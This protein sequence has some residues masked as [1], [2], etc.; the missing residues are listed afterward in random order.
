MEFLPFFLILLVATFFSAV[1]Q[2]LHIPWVVALILGGIIIGPFGFDLLE[3]DETIYFLGQIGIVFLMFMAGLETKVS[4][5]RS[6]SGS[7]FTIAT[8]NTVIPF[9]A[10]FILALFF[11]M[12]ISAA[13]LL[14]IIFISSSVGVVLPSLQSNGLLSTRPGRV[15]TSVVVFEDIFSLFLLAIFLHIVIPEAGFSNLPLWAFLPLFFLSLV[16]LRFIIPKIK[17]LVS[18]KE[19][20]PSEIDEPK[21]DEYG[22]GSSND[23][24]VILVA[25]LGTVVVFG[26]LGIH[27]IAGGFFAGLVLSDTITS[28]KIK[29]RFRTIGYGIFIPIF[30]IIIGVQTDLGVFT[31]MEGVLILTVSVVLTSMISKFLSGFL[32]SKINNMSNKEASLVG[33][34]SMSQLSITLAVAFTGVEAGIISEDLATALVTLTIVSTLIAPLLIRWLARDLDIKVV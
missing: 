16:V 4:D 5:L 11:E 19:Q 10:G 29:E 3:I 9:L 13:I 12:G 32:G 7:L 14:G 23:L 31:K 6:S 28:K 2:R 21:E 8:F 33:A 27:P 17:W 24:R 22:S 26:F 1:F 30:F 15:I 25:L 18:L 20:T 34:S